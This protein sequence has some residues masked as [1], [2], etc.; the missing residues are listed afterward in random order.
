MEKGEGTLYS[1]ED[2]HMNILMNCMYYVCEQCFYLKI[3]KNS[4]YPKCIL[5]FLLNGLCVFLTSEYIHINW[6]SV[7][8]QL[9]IPILCLNVSTKEYHILESVISNLIVV[10]FQTMNPSIP[11]FNYR[12]LCIFNNTHNRWMCNLLS[13]L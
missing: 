5:S 11:F 7:F 6:L 1:D 9:M 2:K 3:T 12:I 10:L 4:L 8:L 13:N